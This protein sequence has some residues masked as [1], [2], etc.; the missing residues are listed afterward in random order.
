MPKIYC[1]TMAPTTKTGGVPNKNVD[2]KH[3]VDS[4]QS[5]AI[6]SSNRH[7]AA[8]H[9]CNPEATMND[10]RRP[11]RRGS[12]L[13]NRRSSWDLNTDWDAMEHEVISNGTVYQRRTSIISICSYGSQSSYYHVLDGYGAE[14]I[15]RNH[16]RVQDDGDSVDLEDDL[17]F[18]DSQFGDREGCS[19]D[20]TLYETIVENDTAE[21]NG[22]VNAKRRNTTTII[23]PSSSA[24]ETAG[25]TST[26]VKR[27]S[28]REIMMLDEESFS[29]SLASLSLS[30][31]RSSSAS[32]SYFRLFENTGS[33]AIDHD[34]SSYFNDED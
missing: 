22:K 10:S 26:K 6:D 30:Q 1:E 17:E 27:K 28:L 34:F 32:G 31:A 25:I 23:H 19:G 24:N 16:N 4:S 5:I 15:G 3:P 8:A 7:R 12:H 29:A 14:D 2:S 11:I 33:N 9:K 13:L 21:I 18:I 20:R